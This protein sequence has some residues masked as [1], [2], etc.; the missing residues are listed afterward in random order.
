MNRSGQQTCT[1]RARSTTT[2]APRSVVVAFAFALSGIGCGGSNEVAIV[3]IEP[4]VVAAGDTFIVRGSGFEWDY[5]A[6]TDAVVG[7]FTVELDDVAA[8]NVEWVDVTQLE[9]RVPDSMSTGIV[10]VTVTGPRGT[11][12]REEAL[13]IRE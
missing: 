5:N 4:R 12:T 11:A 6:F 1:P 10:D 3:T 13:T 7:T 8:E 2:K 9:A